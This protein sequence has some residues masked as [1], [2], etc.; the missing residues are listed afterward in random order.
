MKLRFLCAVM[1]STVIFSS[2]TARAEVAAG[3]M[4]GE[5]TG[6]TVRID[7]FPVMG[8]AWSLSHKWTYLQCD[9]WIIHKPI[10]DAARLDWYLGA[11]GGVGLGHGDAFIG[12][13]LPIGLQAIF[14][15]KFELFGEIAP[16]LGLAPD[17]GLFINGGIGFRY[18]F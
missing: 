10:P 1:C 17:V 16:V 6:F 8:F 15:R 5:P 12:A 14:E 11:G 18:I 4:L 13:R 2:S 3:V 7:R 9:Y